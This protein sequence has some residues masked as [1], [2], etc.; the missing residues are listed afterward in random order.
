M[1]KYRKK[2][3]VV[4]AIQFDGTGESCSEV[5][6]FLA[7]MSGQSCRWKTNTNEGGVTV[8]LEGEMEFRPGDYIIR[9][10][11]GE[12]YPCR[13]DIFAKTYEEVQP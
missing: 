8:S 12:F 4:E 7:D 1:R 6:A 11:A 10:I 5:A 13:S 9:G 2:P 3:V